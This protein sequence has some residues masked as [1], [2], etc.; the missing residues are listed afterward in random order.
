MTLLDKIKQGTWLFTDKQIKNKILDMQQHP[1]KYNDNGTNAGYIILYL[2]QDKGKLSKEEYKSEI[3]NYINYWSEDSEEK[4]K[5]VLDN[6]APFFYEEYED[7]IQNKTSFYHA[8]E[9]CR[10]Q[11]MLC[12]HYKF[13]EDSLLFNEDIDFGDLEDD[14][15]DF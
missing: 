7:A 11:L 15:F 5:K 10:Y 2:Y 3:L 6:Y 13:I 12:L 4:I 1:D 9:S 8:V 14:D